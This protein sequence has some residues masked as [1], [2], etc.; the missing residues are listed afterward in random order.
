MPMISK[1]GI[2]NIQQGLNPISPESSKFDCAL[3][4]PAQEP[5]SQ[6]KRQDQAP[7]SLDREVRKCRSGVETSTSKANRTGKG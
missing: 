2:T 4:L 3:S 6:S 1:Q 7:E 5:A